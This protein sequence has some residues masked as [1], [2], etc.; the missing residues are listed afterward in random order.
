MGA[1]SA[2]PI[3]VMHVIARMNVG[4]PAVEIVELMRGL[5]P[6]EISQRLVTGYVHEDEADFLETQAPDITATRID[7]FGRSIRPTDDALVLAR[8][9]KV[10]RASRPDIVHTH[11]AKAGV[12]GRVAATAAGA[13]TKIVHTHHGHLLHGYFGPA[14]TKAVIQAERRLARI[15]DRIITVGDKV[16]DDLLEAGIGRSDQYTVIR[17]GVSLGP[18]PDKA[19][20]KREL[21]LP[22]GPVIVSM[23][24]RLTQIKRP[25]RFAEVVE[26]SRDR[27]LNAHFLVAGGGDREPWLRERVRERNLPVTM[28]GWRSDLE[29]I[30]AATDIAIL[31]SDNEGTPLSL[32]QAGLAGVPSV[33]T[34]AGSV[35]EVVDEDATGL[36]TG[37]NAEALGDCVA[38]L[39]L[40]EPRR[41]SMGQLARARAVT[42]F[43]PRV[44]L[45]HHA[46]AYDALRGS[47][48]QVA[49]W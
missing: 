5:D 49:S 31:T 1:G 27:G 8:L 34:N 24:G 15:T 9:I 30:L 33:A 44:F 36:V 42:A 13:G 2:G 43:A 37:L 16:R 14:K 45:A 25:D 38:L 4:G 19:T 29:R 48:P 40:D 35:R 23:I 20:A 46:K 18:L 28:L 10:I 21:G 22:E 3:K 6:A 39:V 26:I 17:S 41:N 32:V 12:L 47:T 7:G 11:T